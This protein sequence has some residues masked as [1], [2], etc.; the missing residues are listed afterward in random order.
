MALKPSVFGIIFGHL[1]LSIS[2]FT[3]FGQL[4]ATRPPL[5]S[6]LGPGAQEANWLQQAP[7]N[8][9]QAPGL[10]RPSGLGSWVSG[11]APTIKQTRHTRYIYHT[12]GQKKHCLDVGVNGFFPAVEAFRVQGTLS[13]PSLFTQKLS[14][15]GL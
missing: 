10:T 13:C 14:F 9:Q 2:F 6:V 12:I 5:Y 7:S 3:G 4:T 15:L 8:P 11:E 1:F